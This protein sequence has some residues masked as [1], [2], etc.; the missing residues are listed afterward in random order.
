M[1]TRSLEGPRY[2]GQSLL[3]A[4][5]L[6]VAAIGNA[7]QI[8]HKKS[9]RL[10]QTPS[11]A[12]M[13]APIDAP[14]VVTINAHDELPEKILSLKHELGSTSTAAAVLQEVSYDA[15]DDLRLQFPKWDM[16]FA[17]GDPRQKITRGGLGNVIM[18]RGRL[19]DAKSI[20]IQNGQLVENR[21]LLLAKT[22]LIING[23]PERVQLGVMHVARQDLLQYE[24]LDN[25]LR[26]LKDETPKNNNAIICGDF[27]MGPSNIK[28]YMATVGYVAITARHK[29]YIGSK[30]GAIYDH[31]A[32]NS[33]GYIG[34]TKAIIGKEFR[35]D[36]R[37]VRIRLTNMNKIS[38]YR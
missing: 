8:T 6:G 16:V 17:Y 10:E 29:T 23:K 12:P 34:F 27:N 30:K 35:S 4:T 13:V 31:C 25:A 7:V 38:E 22:Q 24:Q 20:Q 32:Y 37:P 21:A 19:E 33:N 1:R 15:F 9:D 11:V 3:M 28:R 36:H 18:S 26:V 5:M 14:E 2:A